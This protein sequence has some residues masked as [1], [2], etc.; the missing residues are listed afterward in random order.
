MVNMLF[1]TTLSVSAA[2]AYGSVLPRAAYFDLAAVVLNDPAGRD[3]LE[4]TKSKI[5]D[6]GVLYSE[7]PLGDSKEADL[8]NV[9]EEERKCLYLHNSVKS[10]ETSLDINPH[11]DYPD[12]I[13]RDNPLPLKITTSKAVIDTERLGWNKEKSTE[14][15]ASVTADTSVNAGFFSASLSATVYG[16]QRTTGGE[17]GE[18]SKQT[19][20]S[21]TVESNE[22]CP[23]NSICRIV[24]WTYI[25]TIKGTCS[26]IPN[27]DTQ[28]LGHSEGAK[29]SL[30]LFPTCPALKST[31]LEFFK[32]NDDKTQGELSAGPVVEGVKMHR[33]EYIQGLKHERKCSF[34]YALRTKEGDPVKSQAL[35]IESRA[36]TH[37]TLVTEVPA[38]KRWYTK[39]DGGRYCLLENNWFWLANNEFCIPANKGEACKWETRTDLAAPKGHEEKCN[40][41]ATDTTKVSARAENDDIIP[42]PPNTKF[43]VKIISSNLEEFVAQKDNNAGFVANLMDGRLYVEEPGYIIKE[44]TSINECLNKVRQ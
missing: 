22:E 16:N 3:L 27:V 30:G 21:Y 18:S 23:P 9:L 1:W 44:P 4:S 5:V 14:I 35:I 24:T 7:G 10:E 29:L 2:C 8:D 19:E 13:S 33:P 12:R 17:N 6:N 32:F 41:R 26:L 20:W 28:C 37:K 42:P 40:P 39:P 38:A 25:R 31:A 34:S 15:G 36:E 43:G 11:A